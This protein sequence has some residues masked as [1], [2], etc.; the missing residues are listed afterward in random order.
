PGATD[1]EWWDQLGHDI[2]RHRMLRPEDVAAAVE[3][4][5]SFSELGVVE[6]LVMRHLSGDF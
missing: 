3:F 4:V 5:L 1:T 2:P 6:E